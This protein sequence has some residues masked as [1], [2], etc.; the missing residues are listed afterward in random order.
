MRV[1]V[2]VRHPAHVHH[3]RHFISEV[4]KLGH[5]VQIA[6]V[7]KD[8]TLQ[9][10]AAF[11][12]DYF[13][14]GKNKKGLLSKLIE[15]MGQTHRIFKLCKKFKPDLLVGRPSPPLAFSIFFLKKQHLV[16]AED[17][18]KAVFLTAILSYP[19]LKEIHTPVETNLGWFNYKKKP[20]DGYQKLAYL[21]PSLFKPDKIQIKEQI[22]LSQA[23]FLLRISGLSAHHDVGKAG[24]SEK[25]VEK[26]IEIIQPYGNIF[27]SS[28]RKL[29]AKFEKYGL[30][31]NSRDIHHALYFAEILVSDSQSMSLESAL[32]G[33]PSVRFSDFTGKLSVLEELEHKH[34]LTFGIKTSEPEKLFEKVCEILEQPNR[35]AVFQKRRELLLSKKI[36]VTD[37]MLSLL[38][39]KCCD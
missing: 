29:P 21:H 6:A 39:K 4:K 30:R 26:L 24:L 20:Y 5:T 15:I 22:D 35:H 17:D 25:I 37:Y 7:D 2:E 1:L 18:F 34:Q 36:N 16:F 19:F 9:L 11:Q 23:F 27:I 28:E 13:L 12:L 32:L 38:H 3:F 33:T 8:I 10:L 31:I 14:I